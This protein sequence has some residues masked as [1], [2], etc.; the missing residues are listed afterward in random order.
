MV[1]HVFPKQ[2]EDSVQNSSVAVTGLLPHGVN[3]A[4]PNSLVNICSVNIN[5][6]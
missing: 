1:H 3:I 5:S 4:I 2:C 6:S